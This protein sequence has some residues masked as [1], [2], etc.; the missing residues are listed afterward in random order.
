MSSKQGE[1]YSYPYCLLS[2]NCQPTVQGGRTQVET[3]F[4]HKAE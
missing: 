1:A 2:K 3:D 4:N